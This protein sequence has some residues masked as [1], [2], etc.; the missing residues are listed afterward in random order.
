MTITINRSPIPHHIQTQS[1]NN[2]DIEKPGKAIK[3][4]SN[5]PPKGNNKLP[6]KSADLEQQKLMREKIAREK[7]E[8]RLKVMA[9][10]YEIKI[11][12]MK[13]KNSGVK[14][15]SA[16]KKPAIVESKGLTPKVKKEP[17]M[18][19]SI[20]R[21]EKIELGSDPIDLT[22]DVDSVTK[23]RKT[24]MELNPSCKPDLKLKA[25]LTRSTS[26]EDVENKFEISLPEGKDFLRIFKLQVRFFSILNAHVFL[27]GV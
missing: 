1:V 17:E 24:L 27:R 14:Q 11:R 2:K 23:R 10:Q 19:K 5:I 13:L 7:E 18:S 8:K 21:L 15:S 25:D 26:T 22:S 4:V 9:L 20:L 6:L 16:N 12:E 3:P